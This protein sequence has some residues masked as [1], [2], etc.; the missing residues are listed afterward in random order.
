MLGNGSFLR[1]CVHVRGFCCR[2]VQ[3]TNFVCKSQ[4]NVSSK[5]GDGLHMTPW[6]KSRKHLTEFSGKQE[7]KI[8]E[9]ENNQR[10]KKKGNLSQKHKSC[11]AEW[12]QFHRERIFSPPYFS[13]LL[14]SFFPLLEHRTEWWQVTWFQTT[15]SDWFSTGKTGKTS[16]RGIYICQ[17]WMLFSLHRDMDSAGLGALFFPIPSFSWLQSCH[18]AGPTP[19]TMNQLM[20]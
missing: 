13:S 1:G 15:I 14:C 18:R 9:A 6:W 8:K 16:V 7:G 19:S 10:L 17:T 3:F 11:L 20:A 4:F 2:L 5:T 12:I